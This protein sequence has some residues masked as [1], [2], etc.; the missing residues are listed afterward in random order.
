MYTPLGKAARRDWLKWV[1][2]YTIS[3][4]ISAGTVGGMLGALG[5]CIP[6][7]WRQLVFYPIAAFA[8]L[9]S[10]REMGWVR[11]DLPERK[12]QTEKRW[13]HEFSLVTVSIMWGLH[14]GLGFATRITY[15][16]FW[17]LA[18]LIVASGVPLAGIA[19][20]LAYWLGRTLS[21]WLAP[22]L[23]PDSLDDFG[24][25][26]MISAGRPTYRRIGAI[27]LTWCAFVTLLLAPGL[28]K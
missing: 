21:I 10:I 17:V 13:I 9:L 2:A 26:N 3:G 11:F 19:L 22:L 24:L 15:G 16:G 8:V 1:A 18:A 28:P 7:K 27:C 14:I 23:T 5:Q 25:L 6:Q 4:C 12:C 20:M